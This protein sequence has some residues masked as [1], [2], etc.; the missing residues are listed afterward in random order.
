MHTKFYVD[1]RAQLELEERG[2]FTQI[3]RG[4]ANPSTTRTP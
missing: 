4:I 2:R 3:R 1:H